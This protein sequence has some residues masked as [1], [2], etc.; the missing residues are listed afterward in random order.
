MLGLASKSLGEVVTTFG[1]G[2]MESTCDPNTDGMPIKHACESDS[3][4]S[5]VMGGGPEQAA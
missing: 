2:W 3:L 1:P 5:Q 4:P